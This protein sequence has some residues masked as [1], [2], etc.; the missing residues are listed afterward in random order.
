M[1]QA[2]AHSFVR[3]LA[4]LRQALLAMGEK[5]EVFEEQN[6]T[7]VFGTH[8]GLESTIQLIW[9]VE[10]GALH[11]VEVYGSLVP[12][13]RRQEVFNL[14]VFA[15]TKVNMP[16]FQVR[17][18]PNGWK[19][20]FS[21]CAFL[22]HEGRLSTRA[23]TEL[24]LQTRLAGHEIRLIETMTGPAEAAA[25]AAEAPKE[26][27]PT[28]QAVAAASEDA[29]QYAAFA[30]RT[31]EKLAS[32]PAPP[33]F[34]PITIEQR[35][36]LAA[37]FGRDL[38][39]FGPRV[40]TAKIEDYGH[41]FFSKVRVLG[42]EAKDSPEV[43]YAAWTSFGAIV[44]SGNPVGLIGMCADERPAFADDP[45]LAI[46]LGNMA[47]A[48]T[49]SG[50][51]KA[52]QLTSIDDISF[53]RATPEDAALEKEVRQKLGDRIH[54]PRVESFDGGRRVTMWVVSEGRVRRRISEVR[55]NLVTVKEEAVADLAPRT[56]A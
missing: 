31:R 13:E 3:D 40:A 17:K 41:P 26:T 39:R 5:V 24:L 23:V 37:A 35:A 48:W 49:S 33:T 30:S 11:V 1:T 51:T 54:A 21:T 6:A 44:L 16:A 15:N 32:L 36:A 38:P 8:N 2:P 18:N 47:A 7:V 10:R 56:T 12:H 4:E 22:D 34:P 52:E 20:A 29:K 46:I 14:A 19:V 25:R 28:K 45:D 42:L 50:L 55:P 43:A 9:S 27:P 53:P